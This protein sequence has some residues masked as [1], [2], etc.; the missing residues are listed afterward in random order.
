MLEQ[1]GLAMEAKA[2]VDHI[3]NKLYIAYAR[4]ELSQY[5]NAL[6]ILNT[7]E[8]DSTPLNTKLGMSIYWVVFMPRNNYQKKRWLNTL[9]RPILPMNIT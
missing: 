4:K 1:I 9:K 3:Q 8:A 5:A 6:A 7:L 2:S